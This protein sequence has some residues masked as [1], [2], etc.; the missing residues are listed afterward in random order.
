MPPAGP[1][2]GFLASGR[3]AAIVWLQTA[4][5]AMAR[6]GG[7]GPSAWRRPAGQPAS[8][9]GQ[10]SLSGLPW[11]VRCWPASSEPAGGALAVWWPGFRP[12]P[13]P[14]RGSDGAGSRGGASY[15][16]KVLMAGESCRRWM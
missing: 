1:A 6:D 14:I 12:R 9:L 10:I 7:C 11:A 15:G 8:G 5:L 13:A 2:A 3:R 4:G 16:A